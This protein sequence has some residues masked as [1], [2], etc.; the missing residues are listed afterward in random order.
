MA[1]RCLSLTYFILFLAIAISGRPA[2]GQEETP[3][4]AT[5]RTEQRYTEA[6]PVYDAATLGLEPVIIPGRELLPFDPEWGGASPV[7]AG[8]SL[9][10]LPATS[11]P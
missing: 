8:Q 3:L 4:P 11:L 6:I 9:A 1:K 2:T 5:S 10:P 7:A